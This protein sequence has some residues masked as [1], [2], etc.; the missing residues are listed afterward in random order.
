MIN[1]DAFYVSHALEPVRV[2][3][4]DLVDAYLPPYAPRAFHRHGA[5]A[6]PG[7]TW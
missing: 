6:S 4:Q 1:L 2:P 7:A 3:A 5:A